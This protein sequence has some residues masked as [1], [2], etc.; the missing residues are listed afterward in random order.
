MILGMHP[1]AAAAP[2]VAAAPAW[3]HRRQPPARHF[4]RRLCRA[5]AAGTPS[6]GDNTDSSDLLRRAQQLQEAR[7][8]LAE[9]AAALAAAEGL[10]AAER[11][12]LL[13]VIGLPEP[14]GWQQA[15]DAEGERQ[16]PQ[17]ATLPDTQP[18]AAGTQDAGG[19]PSLPG[20]PAWRAQLP[21]HLQSFLLDTGL[22]SVM[23]EQAEAVRK[24]RDWA[25]AEEHGGGDMEAVARMLEEGLDLP[26]LPEDTWDG[27]PEAPAEFLA[28]LQGSIDYSNTDLKGTKHTGR[29]QASAI[30]QQAGATGGDTQRDGG[31]GADG[32][33]TAAAAEAARAAAAQR[34]SDP[35]ALAGAVRFTSDPA[36]AAA[37]ARGWEQAKE[38]DRMWDTRDFKAAPMVEEVGRSTPAPPLPPDV[39]RVY[40]GAERIAYV[41]RRGHLE[42]Q[43]PGAAL[44]ELQRRGL[45]SEDL[46]LQDPFVVRGSLGSALDYLQRLSHAGATAKLSTLMLKCSEYRP[47]PKFTVQT[48]CYIDFP[49]PDWFYGWVVLNHGASSAASAAARQQAAAAAPS[50]GPYS[51]VS[52][53]AIAAAQAAGE[54]AREQEEEA[55]VALVER[56]VVAA[57]E[58]A[59]AAGQPLDEAALVQ[60]MRAAARICLD[61]RERREASEQEAITAGVN[62]ARDA[63]AAAA[64]RSP[65]EIEAALAAAAAGQLVPPELVGVQ[66]ARYEHKGERRQHT[67]ALMDWGEQ[68]RQLGRQ[69]FLAYPRQPGS[70]E[71]GEG[72]EEEEEEEPAW[73]ASQAAFDAEQQRRYALLPA[74]GLTE[75][76]WGRL[77]WVAARAREQPGWL[78]ELQQDVQQPA[79]QQE[80]RSGDYSSDSSRGFGGAE[81]GKE[82]LEEAEVEAVQEE[83]LFPFTFDWEKQRRRRDAGEILRA[84]LGDN[85]ERAMA[86]LPQRGRTRGRGSNS[87][88]QQADEQEGTAWLGGE[89]MTV[90][91]T[92]TYTIDPETLLVDTCGIVWGAV[93]GLQLHELSDAWDVWLE[94]AGL[95]HDAECQQDAEEAWELGQTAVPQA[96]S[97]VP[98]WTL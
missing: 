84:L 18:L 90:Q 15:Q 98:R 28:R 27:E 32:G 43:H 86:Q 62:A 29:R 31:A 94:A 33:A 7:R 76:E 82:P 39:E 48:D 24:D 26:P 30:G 6:G 47:L 45:V 60:V 75:P 72:G 34:T 46:V 95:L 20:S 51:A 63:T 70:M 59:E 25:A 71:E 37:Y 5:A 69:Q 74:A 54:A 96:C 58:A 78:Q 68:H 1:I 10:S 66:S 83:E 12:A 92:F 88:L 21:P 41:M 61:R 91:V 65:E 80:Q 9:E 85:F 3:R 97:W 79:A 93:H 23:D 13:E 53:A 89:C 81:G 40:L 8:Q 52:A 67:W 11:A 55:D 44:L 22:A 42:S 57:H 36:E 35:A 2:Q 87:A 16:A 14:P 49:L 56:M 38:L 77:E 50:D 4:F 64:R 73:R 19:E 17:Q